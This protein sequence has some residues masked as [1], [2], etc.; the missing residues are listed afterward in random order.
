MAPVTDPSHSTYEPRI[1]DP[2]LVDRDG[3]NANQY[4]L[5]SLSCLGAVVFIVAILVLL[6]R[7]N[8]LDR[9]RHHLMPVYNFDPTDEGEDWETQLLEDGL[10]S[11]PV[12]SSPTGGET[13]NFGSTGTT[14]INA[15][16]T[17]SL[18]SKPAVLYTTE[19]HP[20]LAFERV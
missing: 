11:R 12:L 20:K 3:S 6:I 19:Q 14:N 13:T 16:Q 17:Q 2:L 5:V 1:D 15:S 8:K 18:N 4:Y 10:V 7:K 9:L